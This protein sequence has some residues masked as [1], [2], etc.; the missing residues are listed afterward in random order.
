MAT[1]TETAYYT[2]RTINWII[3]GIIGYFILRLLLSLGVQAY[4]AIFPPKAPPPNHA[5]GIL[6]PLTFPQA[7]GNTKFTYTLQTITGN[8]PAAS[9]SAAVYLMPKKPASLLA[10]TQTQ[11]FASKLQFDPTPHQET[12]SI[13]RFDDAQF[14]LRK[15]KYDIVSGNFIVRYGFEADAS[16]FTN[17]NVL[18][19]GSAIALAKQQLLI[20]SLDPEGYKNG[21]IS[22]TYLK[23]K[24][25]S[26]VETSSQSQSDAVRVDFYRE[27]LG[28]TSIVTP[29]PKEGPISFVFSGALNQ[30]QQL[31]QFAYAYW[32]IDINTSA[33]YELITST[34]AWEQLKSGSGY[35]AQGPLSGSTSVTVRNIYLA[36]YDT[37]D[38]QPY[39]QPVFVFSGDDDFVAYVPAISPAWTKK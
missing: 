5:F 31:L 9:P 32:P 21:K 34:Q 8:I 29:R 18:S 23:L 22:V 15:M 12:N 37:Y 30:K 24:G 6:P 17:K 1:L 26:L 35:I 16:V 20:N 28:D 14:P 11:A 10:L 7:E 25:D 19:Q 39:L 27:N 38:Q 2:R 4:L 3:L 13:Y 33:T 36:Y